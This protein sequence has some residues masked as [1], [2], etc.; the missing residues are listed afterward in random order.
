MK[1]CLIISSTAFFAFLSY[2]GRPNT[3]FFDQWATVSRSN[4]GRRE[5]WC[6]P[7]ALATLGEK[8]RAR[9]HLETGGNSSSRS[10]A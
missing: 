10:P 9:D 5:A 3:V 7:N 4:R 6:R 2:F 8:Y 1:N